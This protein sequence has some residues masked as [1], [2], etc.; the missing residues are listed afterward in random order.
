MEALIL[1]PHSQLFLFSTKEIIVSE[2]KK[3][4]LFST[5]DNN[6]SWMAP[7]FG[8]L[9]AKSYNLYTLIVFLILYVACMVCFFYL[10][11][12]S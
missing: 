6:L 10:F 12:V 11:I 1:Y 2:D 9:I 7:Q 3:L 5:K 8:V 4:F